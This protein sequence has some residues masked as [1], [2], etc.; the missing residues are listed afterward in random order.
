ML[1]C[2]G[3]IVAA[4]GR[5]E[6]STV[7]VEHPCAGSTATGRSAGTAANSAVSARHVDVGLQMTHALSLI[8]D[9]KNTYVSCCAAPNLTQVTERQ[10]ICH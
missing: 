6:A 9:L 5:V 2:S 10:G 7:D 4:S 1:C 8:D 3:A